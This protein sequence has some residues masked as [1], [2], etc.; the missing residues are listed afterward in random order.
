MPYYYGF[1]FTYLIIIV[2][3]ILLALWAQMRVQSAFNRYSKVYASRGYTAADVARMILDAN[4]LQNIGLER[5]AG[6]LTDHYDPKAGVIRL[7]ESVYGSSS[8]AAIGVAAHEAGHAVQ[9]G[10]NYAPMRIRSAIVPITNIGSTLSFPIILL[11]VLFAWEP[12]VLFGIGLFS[13]VAVFQFV[14]LPVE[15]NASGRALAVLEGEHLLDEEE[16]KGAQKVLSAAALTY[17]AAL[18]S[19]LAQLLRLFLLFGRRRND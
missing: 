16:L 8:V 14:T 10:E 19:T 7:S 5:V 17:V 11:G 4:G 2:P 3:T 9:H 18:I 1:D 12:L 13:L 6:N 15:F